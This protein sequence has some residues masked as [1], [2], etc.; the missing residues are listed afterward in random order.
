MEKYIISLDQGTTSSRAV[1]IDQEGVIID[2]CQQEI[3]QIYPQQSWVEEDPLEI[4]SSIVKMLQECIKSNGLKPEQIASIGI[5]NQRETT[6]LWNKETGVPVYNAIVWQCR[7]GEEMCQNL[8]IDGWSDKIHNKTGLILDPYFSGTKI[9]WILDNVPGVNKLAR[10][11]KILFGTV[12]SWLLWNLTDKKCHYTDYSNA[13][14]TMI[15]NINSQKWDE[16]LL[17]LFNIPISILPKVMETSGFFGNISKNILGAEI[18]INSIIG[19]QQS[20]LFGQLCTN[21]GDIKNTYGTGCFTLMNIGKKPIF[22]KN[23]LL[24]TIAWKIKGRCYYAVEGSVFVGG[25][26]I[27]WLRDELGII[28]E[29]S[30]SEK[31]ALS[32]SDCNGVVFVSTFQGVGTPYWKSEVKAEITGISRGTTKAHIVRAAL[33]SIAFRS[34]EVITTMENDSG[35]NINEIK[36]DGGA[37]NNNFLME[38]QAGL[39]GVEIIRPQNTEST[40]LGA[41]YMAGLNIGFWKDIDEL[42]TLK[43]TDRRFKPNMSEVNRSNNMKKWKSAMNKAIG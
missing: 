39:S 13:S 31:L 10:E 34:M 9:K 4:Y 32:V 29:A 23:G 15:Y 17:S 2:I 41:G 1:L 36:V 27:Q 37:C 8:E 22:S 7:R 42:K 25:A 30:E 40:A 16:E 19:D 20:A 12:D 38:F 43:H 26:V 33:E 35:I 24:T 5:T 18:P 28:K 6:I 21:N 14:R 3:K 11:G